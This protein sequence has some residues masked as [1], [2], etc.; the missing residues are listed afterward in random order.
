MLEN[1]TKSPPSTARFVGRFLWSGIVFISFANLFQFVFGQSKVNFR[2]LHLSVWFTY[3]VINNFV[4]EIK[5][6][7]RYP[8]RIININF[9]S[10]NTHYPTGVGILTRA[11]TARIRASQAAG[12]MRL[13]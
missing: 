4:Y 8:W 11:K 1:A 6:L 3:A 9:T 13:R 7:S 12:A 5:Q 10:V 2:N